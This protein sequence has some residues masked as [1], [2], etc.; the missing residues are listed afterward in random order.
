MPF[1]KLQNLSD[2]IKRLGALMRRDFPN[3]VP[4]DDRQPWEWPVEKAVKPG[5]WAVVIGAN[6][7]TQEL[8]FTPIPGF[9]DAELRVI[10]FPG[11]PRLFIS[12]WDTKAGGPVCISTPLFYEVIE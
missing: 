6:T 7:G 3:A 1:R 2:T 8:S 11:P 5:N 10:H 9:R 12:G 4:F